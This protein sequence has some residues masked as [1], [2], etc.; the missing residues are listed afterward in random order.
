[1]ALATVAQ[2]DIQL[3]TNGGFETGDFTGWNAQAAPGSGGAW[4]VSSTTLA[5]ISGEL[6]AG[7]A[8]GSFYAVTGQAG[9]GAYAL[10]QSFTVA[11]GATDV[12]LSFDLF[13]ND[14]AGTIIPGP[15]NYT[16]SDVQ[17]AT[18]DLL[19]GTADPFSTAPADV[20]Q[21]FYT[22]AD[23]TDGGPAPYTHYSFDIT[24]WVVAGDTYQI[25][26]GDA[27]NLSFFSEGVDNVSVVETTGAAATP[28]PSYY[29]L[30]LLGIGGMIAW[31]RRYAKA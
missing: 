15:L 24:N 8:S 14:F 4:A 2:A 12:V 3:L 30:I 5:P 16:D 28:E 26:F 7:P 25:R 13:A 6:T 19:T 11:P 20:I 9:P 22:G 29:L 1:M 31:K 21:N 17:F 18:A 27:D 10:T 23:N